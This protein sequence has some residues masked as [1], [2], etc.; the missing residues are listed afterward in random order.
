MIRLLNRGRQARVELHKHNIVENKIDEALYH[1][2]IGFLADK[3]IRSYADSLIHMDPQPTSP[4][5]PIINNQNDMI[6]KL[7]TKQNE[8]LIQARTKQKILTVT[9]IPTIT[10]YTHLPGIEDGQRLRMLQS[11]AFSCIHNCIET[12]CGGNKKG[13]NC[14]FGFPKKRMPVTVLGTMCPDDEYT[15]THIYHKRLNT[16]TSNTNKWALLYWGANHD[17]QTIM[18]FS[19]INRYATKYVTKQEQSDSLVYILRQ[20][21]ADE[22][23][24]VRMSRN[25][26]LTQCF[27]TAN[28]YRSDMTRHQMYYLALDLPESL[29]NFT[30]TPVSINMT[31]EMK[32]EI[33]EQGIEVPKEFLEKS[34]IYAYA[35]RHNCINDLKDFPIDIDQ[36]SLYDFLRLIHK[37]TW[38]DPEGKSTDKGYKK[39][40]PLSGNKWKFVFKKNQDNHVRIYNLK[41]TD[42]PT[43]YDFSKYL[44]E[45]WD[46]IP[47][48]DKSKLYRAHEELTLFVPWKHSVD[49]TFLDP[50]TYK[51]INVLT[52]DKK[53]VT[54][55]RMETFMEIYMN[56]VQK[57][58][59]APPG[60]MWHRQNQYLRS[61]WLSKKVNKNIRDLRADN[62]GVFK[63]KFAPGSIDQELLPT[64][65]PQ[66]YEFS[67]EQQAMYDIPE[68]GIEFQISQQLETLKPKTEED[69]TVI[70]TNTDFWQHQNDKSKTKQNNS[71]LANPPEPHVRLEDLTE[72]QRFAFDRA[73]DTKKSKIL[74]I[75]GLAGTG[76]SAIALLIAKAIKDRGQTCQI[77]AA[78]AKAASQFNGP[79]FHG[80]LGLSAIQTFN[81]NVSK[82]TI[83]N[84]QK[85]Y[86][87]GLSNEC[88]HFIFDEINT[89]SAELFEMSHSILQQIFCSKQPWGNRTVIFLG[90][91]LQL[92]PVSGH[93]VI[94]IDIEIEEIDTINMTTKT[95]RVTR[96]SE[97]KR[98]IDE[99][100]SRGQFLFKKHCA[101]NVIALTKCQRSEGLLPKIMH[102]IRNGQTTPETHK[103]LMHLGSIFG[104]ANYDKGIYNDNHTRELMNTIQTIQEAEKLSQPLFISFANYQVEKQTTERFMRTLNP[105]DFALPLDDLLVLY[106]GMSVMIVKNI[107]TQTGLTNGTIG[108]IIDI[109]YEQKDV[110]ALLAGDH[111]RPHCLILNVPEYKPELQTTTSVTDTDSSNI[112]QYNEPQFS[113]PVPT[114]VAIYPTDT[115]LTMKLKPNMKTI[116]SN[117]DKKIETNFQLYLQ[118]T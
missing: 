118:K 10:R 96:N 59:V 64:D 65:D 46:N 111:P 112:E 94:D 60:S 89:L 54:K 12:A 57:G 52:D 100:V 66:V 107:N 56:L 1:V 91:P 83:Q 93:N 19:Q 58:K 24:F 73:V 82:T 109:C 61:M 98:K 22:D 3:Y 97:W 67:N 105:R 76:K 53:E 108:T 26:A 39:R 20:L 74:Y 49:K 43:S 79:T 11:A 50:L 114:W 55:K 7:S 103:M 8:A 21:I 80:A 48:D 35:E 25:G 6:S 32:T 4:T 28:Q 90:D 117:S 95:R 110:E 27:T 18:N 33:N 70:H 115:Q 77:A 42:D 78:T 29:S 51:E 36:I 47:W 101:P 87:F 34:L 69:I 102:E 23:A 30:V 84:L 99:Q 72:Q 41:E 40:N 5:N 17:F 81:T 113:F 16:R 37:H 9:D 15:E 106:R 44:N 2:R 31:S 13:E 75:T 62:N 45:T 68:N 38:V 85:L 86:N 63:A 88:T 71:F 92:P 104:N 116:F 14:R